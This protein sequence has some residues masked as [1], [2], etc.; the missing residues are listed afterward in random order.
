MRDYGKAI[1][2]TWTDHHG[3]T[4]P[5]D[6]SVGPLKFYL[7]SHAA[8]RSFV[9][10]RDQYGCRRC[11][12]KAISVP[13][14]YDGKLALDT[15]KRMA[16]GMYDILVVDHIITRRAGGGHHHTN[17]Q[18]LCET[19]NKHKSREDGKAVAAVHLEVSYG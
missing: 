9:F 5:V 1:Q 3:K 18:T 14:D 16:S 8:L 19:C 12:T 11:S 15:D 4:W 10:F 7:P 13:V 6:S 17:L 2:S